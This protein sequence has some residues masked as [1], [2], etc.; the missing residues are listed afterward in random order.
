MQRKQKTI[1]AKI[2]LLS[3]YLKITVSHKLDYV[4]IVVTFCHIRNVTS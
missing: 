4:I 3:L 1:K 2:W